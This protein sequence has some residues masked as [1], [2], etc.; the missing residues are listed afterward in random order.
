MSDLALLQRWT[1]R[2]DAQAFKEIVSRYAPMVYATCRRILGNATEAEDLTQECF[3][4]LARTQQ[5][6]TEHLGAWLHRVATNRALDSARSELQRKAR[7][8]RFVVEHGSRVETEWN[9]VYDSIDEAIAELPDELRVPVVAYFLQNESHAKIARAIGVPR[10]TVSRRISRAVESIGTALRSRGVTVSSGVLASLMGANLAEAA[11]VPARLATALGKLALAHSTN[12]VV[13]ATS[14]MVVVWKLAGGLFVMKKTIAVLVLAVTALMGLWVVTKGE[15][16]RSSERE[17]ET[18]AVKKIEVVSEPLPDA[19]GASVEGDRV[20]EQR[21]PVRESSTE[22]I[23]P[24][25]ISGKVVDADTGEGVAGATVQARD[26]AAKDGSGQQQAMSGQDGQFEFAGLQGGA[27]LVFKDWGPEDYAGSL[28]EDIVDLR[29]RDDE[30]KEGILLLARKGGTVSGLVTDGHGNPVTNATLLLQPAANASFQGLKVEIG[31]GV[32]GIAQS[33]A[34]GRYTIRGVKLN[35]RCVVVA[36]SLGYAPVRSPEFLLPAAGSSQQVDFQLSRGSTIAGWVRDRNGEAK[37][38]AEIALFLEAD[39][40]NITDYVLMQRASR[41][42][43]NTQ[44]G[45]NGEF[46]IEGLPAGTYHL[47]AG[48]LRPSPAMRFEGGGTPVKVDGITDVE[49]VVVVADSSGGGGHFIAGRVSNAEGAPIR[50]AAVNMLALNTAENFQVVTDESGTFLADGL[51]PGPFI[52]SVTAAGYS[53][54]ILDSVQVDVE[55]LAILLNRKGSVRGCVVET[56]SGKPIAGAIV[57]IAEQDAGRD[58]ELHPIIAKSF[59]RL[60][61]QAANRE[62][63]LSR[64]DGVFELTGVEPGQV[65]LKAVRTG[66][67]KAFSQKIPIEP[68]SRTDRVVLQ[69]SRGALVE[70]VVRTTAGAPVEGASILVVESEREGDLWRGAAEERLMRATNDGEG[71]KDVA[72]KS[73]KEGKFIIEGLSDG[74]YWLRAIASGY[75]CSPVLD[76]AVANGQCPTSIKL[77]VDPGGAIEGYVTD[78]GAPRRDV[79]IEVSTVVGEDASAKAVYTDAEGHFLVGHVAPGQHLVRVVDMGRQ[80]GA[81]QAFPIRVVSGETTRQDA[82]FNGHAVYGLVLGLPNPEEWHVAVLYVPDGV[83]PDDPPNPS[84]DWPAFL[85]GEES[86]NDGG[87]YSIENLPDGVFKLAVI[88]LE[89]PVPGAQK[90]WETI[91]IAGEDLAFDVKVSE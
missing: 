48:G 61:K 70:G 34:S 52:C 35:R 26:V 65:V 58:L 1:D 41:R 23:L 4:V 66:Y 54:A 56:P 84:I 59:E 90:A 12:S 2:R 82:V 43:E 39:F 16:N 22:A 88:P 37:P 18:G 80:R 53:Q 11:V 14:F 5:G 7:E 81:V 38:H 55:D 10:R 75:A 44:S 74:A 78:N 25:G 76:L 49:N 73:A 15:P 77:V 87:S 31:S 51:G 86:I 63:D 36:D 32:D 8:E 46:R 50:G 9:D 17:R 69:L 20:A 33:D 13:P 45:E 27:Y 29:L 89:N 83:N 60:R 24:P 62:K 57:S 67:A 19:S 21:E 79:R 42:A 3:E 47:Y 68:D 85:A 71:G 40:V 72:A 28:A 6:P 30:R 91:A 64:E